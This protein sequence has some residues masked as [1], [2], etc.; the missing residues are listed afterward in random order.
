V[1]PTGDFFNLLLA[2]SIGRPALL[3]YEWKLSVPKIP[4]GGKR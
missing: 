1:E 4:A 2:T 3:E